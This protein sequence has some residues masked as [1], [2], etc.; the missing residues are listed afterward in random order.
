MAAAFSPS[1]M[2]YKPLWW[3]DEIR[4]IILEP[5]SSSD[6]IRCRLIHT[7]LGLQD[8]EALSYE[9]G[10][11]AKDLEI[12]INGEPIRVRRNLHSALWHIRTQR[13]RLLWIDA[14]CINQ[15]DVSER[16]HQVCL[17]GRIYS[18]A[19]NVVVWLGPA[20]NDSDLAMD[21]L[22]QLQKLYNEEGEDHVYVANPKYQH[23]Q[24]VTKGPLMQRPLS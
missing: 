8:Y 19:E 7:E 6:P 17:M 22:K 14:L 4:L 15:A 11:S 1:A 23:Q 20:A 18:Q 13:E 24:H 12:S 9:W 3:L 16:N 5:G 21:A 2:K 10:T